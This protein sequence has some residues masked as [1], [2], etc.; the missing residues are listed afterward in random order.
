MKPLV[1][2]LPLV[3]LALLSFAALAQDGATV[4]SVDPAIGGIVSATAKVEK[5]AGNFGFT[6]GPV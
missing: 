2:S 4:V 3:F 1:N 6:E 5:V